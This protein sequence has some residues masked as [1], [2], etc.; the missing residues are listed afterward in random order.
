VNFHNL[1]IFFF[2]KWKKKQEKFVILG[3]FKPVFEI[4]EMRL[5]ICLGTSLVAT[6]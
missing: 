1:V 5:V 4:K 2:R 6:Q 3:D